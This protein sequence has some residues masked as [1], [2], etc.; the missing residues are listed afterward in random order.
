MK[1]YKQHQCYMPEL[2]RTEISE[3]LVGNSFTPAGR[4]YLNVNIRNK[5]IDLEAQGADISSIYLN[6]KRE[7]IFR[8]FI[9]KPIWYRCHGQEVAI[10]TNESDVQWIGR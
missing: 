6:P 10:W 9:T 5:M 8:S 7:I 3:Q 4:K 1:L 2:S